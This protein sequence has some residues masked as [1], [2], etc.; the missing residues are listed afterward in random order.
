MKAL[1]NEYLNKLT[2]E[3]M[4][5]C[6][7]CAMVNTVSAIIGMCP[8]D[9]EFICGNCGSKAFLIF[10]SE[11]QDLIGERTITLEKDEED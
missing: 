11:S 8:G 7:N 10:D 6:C 2:P 4:L 9:K 5:I 3:E 1:T